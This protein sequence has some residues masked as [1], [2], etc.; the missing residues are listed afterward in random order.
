MYGPSVDFQTAVVSRTM[1]EN[2]VVSQDATFLVP[3]WIPVGFCHPHGTAILKSTCHTRKYYSIA[4][5]LF[6][7]WPTCMLRICFKIIVSVVE[8]GLLIEPWDRY[9]WTH[10]TDPYFC[11]SARLASLTATLCRLQRRAHASSKA[12]VVM[13]LLLLT[14]IVGISPRHVAAIK[15]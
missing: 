3:K 7:I 13:M 11:V 14:P 15:S 12:I 4:A 9:A 8:H 6:A 1:M 5:F 2:V 10:S